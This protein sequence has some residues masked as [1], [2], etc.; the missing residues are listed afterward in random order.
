MSGMQAIPHTNKVKKKI[1]T[2]TNYIAVLILHD[3]SRFGTDIH[4][5]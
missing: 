3:I 2:K 1:S 4:N 5:C